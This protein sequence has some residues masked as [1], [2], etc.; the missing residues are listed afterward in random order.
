MTGAQDRLLAPFVEGADRPFLHFKEQT[1]SF[2]DVAARASGY[3]AE[4]ETRGIQPGDRVAVIADSHPDLVAVLLGHHGRG[5]VHVPINT[6][7]R[8]AEVSHILTDA[9]P[10]LVLAD[11]EH[12]D[13]ARASAGGRYELRE[14]GQDAFSPTEAPFIQPR[15]DGDPALMIYTSGTTAKSKG[16]VL[17]FAAVANAIGSL[18]GLWR[19][20]SSDEL[21]LGLP[22]FHVHGLCIGVHGAMLHRMSIRL[23]RAF[24]PAA[25]VRG[26]ADGGTVFMGV[27]TMY[28]RLVEHLE[29]S[30]TAATTVARGRLF[31][32]GSA[33]LTPDLFA[34]FESLTGHQI[35]ERYGMSETLI[36]LSNSL[37]RPR[38][39]GRVGRPIPGI[40]ARIVDDHG[41]RVATGEIGE[42][43]VRGGRSDGWLLGQ[44]SGDEGFLSG[45]RVVS[46]R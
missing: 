17:S 27:P 44:R 2:A 32:A 37:D 31:T 6:R 9:R 26:I 23:L 46:N 33:A 1:L 24:E 11:A 21:V 12:F 8:E 34:R 4:L 15:T 5:V 19:W 22:L 16:V 42:L 41:A 45:R 28:R 35:V 14:I 10:S 30:P 20:T 18:T 43:E 3:A 38:K 25:V 36:T 40:E 7:Y 13:V 29:A 39:P